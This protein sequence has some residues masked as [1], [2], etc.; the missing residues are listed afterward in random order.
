MGHWLV[1]PESYRLKFRI[2]GAGSSHHGGAVL[3]QQLATQQAS[4]T[5]AA[6]CYQPTTSQTPQADYPTP[7][8]PYATSFYHTY[9]IHVWNVFYLHALF[10]PGEPSNNAHIQCVVQYTHAVTLRQQHQHTISM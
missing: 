8:H 6:V 2:F 5:L 1:G 3:R 7:T 10:H 4:A 9:C